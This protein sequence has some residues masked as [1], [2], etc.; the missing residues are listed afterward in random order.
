MTGST[1][2]M[3]QKTLT[4]K[5]IA[6][7]LSLYA[8]TLTGLTFHLQAIGTEAGLDQGSAM[9]IFVPVS[10]ITIPVGFITAWLSDRFALKRLIFI[11][12]FCQTA[13]ALSV[14]FLHTSTGYYSAVIFLGLCGGMFGPLLTIAFPWFFGRLHLG[15]INGK[16]TSYL[17]IFS[18][19]GPL[20]FSTFKDLTGSF[21]NALYFFAILPAII[22]LFCKKISTEKIY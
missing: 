7:A 15:A 10:F 20:I 19:L 5:I 14:A 18:A 17:V 11:L 1:I 12:A 2:E 21:S 3:A 4:F 6:L 8:M 9:A 16:V 13:A 22:C